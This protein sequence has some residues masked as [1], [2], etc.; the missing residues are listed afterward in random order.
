L[1]EIHPFYFTV[2]KSIITSGISFQVHSYID[3]YYERDKI[4]TANFVENI[5]K[6]YFDHGI[7][8]E[9]MKADTYEVI[10]EDTNSC[11]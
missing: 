9:K 11:D 10:N 8:L 3:C 6:H 4:I 5:L 7:A 1:A 2:Y